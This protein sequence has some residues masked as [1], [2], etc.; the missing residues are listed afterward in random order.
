M[1]LKIRLAPLFALCLLPVTTWGFD[2]FQPLPPSPPIPADNP[3]SAAKIAL[4]KSLFFDTKLLGENSRISCNS[5]HTLREGGDDNR[6]LAQGQDGRSSLRSAPGLWN[7]GFQTVLYWD[8]RSTS[9]ESQTLD[10]LRDPLVTQRA[11]VGDAISYLAGSKTYQDRFAAAFPQE[12]EVSGANLAKAMASFLRSLLTPNSPFDRFI[13][14]DKDAIS[15]SAKRGMQIFN[16]IG[17]ASCHFGVNYAGP[18]PGPAMGLGDGFYELFPNHVGTPY[19]ARYGIAE[20]KGRYEFTGHPGEKYMWRV[21]PLRNI[22]VTGPYFHNGSVD[23]LAE[24]VRVMAK[25]QLKLN[26]D[27]NAVKDIASFLESLTGEMKLAK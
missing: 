12:P 18:A 10:H 11:S 26:L 14:G 20:D 8:G 13:Q 22:A 25:T 7:I 15:A 16:D 9:L 4:G 21:P 27:G 24:A 1:S 19:D 6:A 3:Q 23:S 5:C 2:Y 17:C